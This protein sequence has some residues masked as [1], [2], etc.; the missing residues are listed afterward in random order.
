MTDKD[1]SAR[2]LACLK[3]YWG[4]TQFRPWQ[5]ETILSVLDERDSLT[6]LP[7]G[8]GKSLCF[9]LPAL[10]KEGMAVVISP[11]ISLMKDQVDGLKDMGVAAEYLNSSQPAKEQRAVIARIRE[12]QVKLLYISPERLLTGWTANLLKAVPLSFF[13]IDEA[14]C[15]SHWG[16]D[17]REDYRGLGIIKENFPSVNIHAFTATATKEVQ[18][19]ILG[20]LKH[21]NPCVNIASVDRQNLF[22]RVMPRASI[23]SQI[24]E[25]L[26]RHPRDRK[27]TRLNS[28]H[29]Q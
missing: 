7:T 27:S 21:N 28:S 26:G 12:R 24:V 1:I 6:V 10:L 4:Y 3:Q 25:V 18:A 9:Q 23:I 29:S 16:H 2:M 20:Q 22:Y 5:E 13:V 8:G 19:D 15:I 11:L 14:H 17:F